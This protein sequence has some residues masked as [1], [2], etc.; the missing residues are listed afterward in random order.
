[1]RLETKTPH[2]IRNETINVWQAPE[3]QP[4]PKWLAMFG[5]GKSFPIYFA[6]SSEAEVRDKAEAFRT[7]VLGKYE[8]AFQA[9]MDNI[10]KAKERKKP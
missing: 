5:I 2:P 9:K 3:S 7:D 10:R 1:M 8:A 4:G 6:G